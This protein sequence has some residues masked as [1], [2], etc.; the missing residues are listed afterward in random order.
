M[1]KVKQRGGTFLGLLIGVLLGLG[2]ALAVA[3]LVTKGSANFSNKANVR[4][5]EQDAEETQRNKT[6]D[7]NAPLYGKNPVK[8]NSAASGA[9]GAEPA[10][11]AVAA[12]AIPTAAS[13]AVSPG[14]SAPVAKAAASK[15]S[16]A[17]ASASAASALDKPAK[18]ASD[19]PIG[20][21]AKAA[22]AAGGANPGVAPS[23][24]A[25]PDPFVYFVQAGA[26]RTEDD[27]Q[28]QRGRL[29]LMGIETKVT[30]REQAGRTVF[31]VRVGPLQQKSDANAMKERL[32]GSGVESQVV[33]VQ[34]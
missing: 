4:T 23:T 34:R 31:R 28:A 10:A 13:A 24:A 32:E 27:A 16:I 17:K 3:V 25:G 21:I 9:I 2:L 1:N 7:P 22:G 19:D 11:S 15:A 30:E 33:M 6:W 20:D 18:T 12:K 8:P 26:F 29:Q 14:A 5:P